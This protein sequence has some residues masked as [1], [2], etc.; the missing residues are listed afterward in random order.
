MVRNFSSIWK[1]LEGYYSA[2]S[3]S[4][5]GSVDVAA[6]RKAEKVLGLVF[7]AGYKK[8][9]QT[10]GGGGI[11]SFFIYGLRQQAE[12]GDN[13]WSVI[14]N[15]NFYKREQEWPGIEDWVVISDDGRGN[16]IGLTPRGEVWLSD[17]DSGFEQIK[18][19]DSFEEFLWRLYHDTLYEEEP[20]G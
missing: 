5:A 12:M 15:T 13:L 19:A 6:V 18:L 8:Y 2:S 20:G 14:Q 1:L 9:L 11:E 16:P 10:Y 7:P 4:Q 17:H 3:L